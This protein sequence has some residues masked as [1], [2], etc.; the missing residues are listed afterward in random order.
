MPIHP[1]TVD[2]TVALYYNTWMN[3]WFDPKTW[4]NPGNAAGAVND[5]WRQMLLLPPDEAVNEPNTKQIM[6][7]LEAH[8]EALSGIFEN[9]TRL[10]ESSTNA[11]GDGK[12]V[13]ALIAE[14]SAKI[15]ALNARVGRLE[16]A[17]PS[18]KANRTQPPKAVNAK[19]AKTKRLK[20]R[21]R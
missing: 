13:A 14:M 15:A 8:H 10:N 5:L 19:T 4:L 20:P 2:A 7:V 21:S 1:F 3:D 17:S 11:I 16:G 9:L 6:S 12:K 18:K